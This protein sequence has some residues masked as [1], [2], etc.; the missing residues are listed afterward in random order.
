MIGINWRIGGPYGWGVFGLNLAIELARTGRTLPVPLLE[1]MSRDTGPLQSHLLAP[2]W[3]EQRRLAAL[4][5]AQPGQ[6][7]RL[8]GIVL[9]ALMGEFQPIT[10][11]PFTGTVNAGL[12]FFES[13]RFSTDG[14]RRAAGFDRIVAGSSWNAEVLRGLGLT[15]VV[16]APQG[17][18]PALFHPAPKVDLFPG[19][20]VVFAGGKLEY[21]KGQDIALAAFRRF[22]ARHPDALLLAAWQNPFPHLGVDVAAGPHVAADPRIVPGGLD[23]TGWLLENGLPAGSFIDCG[24]VDHWKLAPLLR[25]ADAAI[26]PNRGEGGTNL[27][28]MEA[29]ACGV[30]SILSANTGHLDLINDGDLLVLRHQGHARPTRH[31]PATEGWGESDPDEVVA[32]LE[33][34]YSDR[35]HARRCGAAAARRMRDWNWS[36]QVRRLVEQLPEAPARPIPAPRPSACPTP[37]ALPEAAFAKAVAHHRNGEFEQA[38]SLYRE[39]LR[40]RPDSSA[41]ADNFQHLLGQ[42]L[43][44]ALRHLNEADFLA[45]ARQARFVLCHRPTDEGAW[46]ILGAA[47]MNRKQLPSARHAFRNAMAS[48]PD[49]A[50]TYR[51][52]IYLAVESGQ[53]DN[54]GDTVRRSLILYPEE[55]SSAY[56]L[57]VARIKAGD[58]GGARQLLRLILAL[59]PDYK[60]AWSDLGVVMTDLGRLPEAL[61]AF[62][63]AVALDSHLAAAQWGKAKVFLLQGRFRDGWAGFAWRLRIPEWSL[64]FPHGPAWDGRVG[65]G[66]TILVYGEL[67]HGDTLLFIRYA[68]ALARHNRVVA[69]V[70][71]A[72]VRLLAGLPGLSAC[73]AL[74]QEV[75]AF[76][77]CCSLLDLPQLCA[78]L[79]TA[80]PR[81]PY[82]RAEPDW[83]AAWRSRLSALPGIRVGLVWS[84]D[85]RRQAHADGAMNRRRSLPLAA[86]APLGSI[87]GISFISLQKGEAAAEALPP[88]AG[89]EVFNPMSGVEDFADTAGLLANLDLVVSVDTAVAHLAGALGKPVWMLSR[90]EAG[91]P[92]QLDD[93]EDTIWYPTMRI[94]RQADPG[95]WGPVIRRVVA[96]LAEFNPAS[97]T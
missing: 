36:K 42:A 62:Q 75:P 91:F 33:Q 11:S 65:D 28:A 9:H 16:L 57:A 40:A 95:D 4:A 72:L 82:L 70:Q 47:E 27:V 93:R 39:L 20:F 54:V 74:G 43:S 59:A 60:S 14:V 32:L 26:F 79:A 86:L 19:R 53:L 7:C 55:S 78:S 22:H 58:L 67:G 48:G 80:V 24:L 94:F 71:P 63:R 18:D 85:P 5:A 17:V 13:T 45:A 1:P 41:I 68:V 51:Y 10:P 73:V 92:W 83:A 64:P 38:A 81:A 76:D 21:R 31:F 97:A 50:Q 46:R 77:A 49:N 23:V 44:Q 12:I 88:P 96:A 2:G 90:F 89:L 30:P 84:G 35:G 56:R 29:M 34:L 69:A 66:R 3:A 15:N 25:E 37:E 87:P 6:P 61:A 8:D 52:L